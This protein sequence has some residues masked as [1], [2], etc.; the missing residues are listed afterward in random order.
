MVCSTPPIANASLSSKLGINAMRKSN[1]ALPFTRT[2]Y[3]FDSRVC[4][5]CAIAH[6]PVGPAAMESISAV[7]YSIATRCGPRRRRLRPR[8]PFENS[9]GH[10]ARRR[11]FRNSRRLRLF[12]DLSAFAGGQGY[13]RMFSLQS[14]GLAS[15]LMKETRDQMPRKLSL[16]LLSA[17]GCREGGRR[18]FSDAAIEDADSDPSK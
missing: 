17:H 2:V 14:G 4:L 11:A 15:Q 5:R 3:P 6:C 9:R 8:A 18:D 10:A 13:R 16:S 1:G 7:R 12:I